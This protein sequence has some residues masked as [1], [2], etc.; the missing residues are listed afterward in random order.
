MATFLYIVFFLSCLVLIVAVLLQPGKTDAGALFTSGISSAALNPRGTQSVLSKLTIT[1]A[2]VFM[3]SA[4]F[5]AL[6]AISGET[7][8]LDAA[9]DPAKPAENTNANTNA[10]ANANS[11]SAVNTA[12][13][14]SN[15]NS[16]SAA[17]TNANTSESKPAPK[18]DDKKE[19]SDKEAVDSK[20]E[21]NT[22]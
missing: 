11:D 9:K 6:P 10:N 4:L 21:S 2:T 15:T 3:L 14:N 7:S 18:A 13:K 5:L 12:N 16:N 8:V 20:S 1:A 17:T 19:A 22:K